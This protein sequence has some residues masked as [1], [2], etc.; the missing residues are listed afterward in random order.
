M[1]D[2]LMPPPAMTAEELLNLHLPD[3]QVE[4]VRGVLVV[5]EPPGLQHGAVAFAIAARIGEFVRANDLGIVLAA[6]TGFKLFSDPD[7]VRAPDAAFIRR[8]R[9]P[10]PLPRGYAAFAPDLAVE[11]VSPN[12]RAGEILT[13]VGD[14]LNAGSRLVWVIDPVRRSARVYRADGSECFLTEHDALAGEG[15][16]PGFTCALAEIW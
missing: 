2:Q 15:L 14:W 12:D 9:V 5:R 13:K 7:T 11:V 10:D 4:L 6:E 16:L 8:E 3:R 1:P